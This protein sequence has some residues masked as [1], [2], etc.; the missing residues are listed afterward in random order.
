MAARTPFRIDLDGHSRQPC[1][2]AVG[3]QQQQQQL[4]APSPPAKLE[5]RAVAP[6]SPAAVWELGWEEE[7]ESDEVLE[8]HHHS[9]W[10]G[11]LRVA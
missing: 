5:Q 7:E 10:G 1:H 2:G 11:S 4:A 6:N 8:V 3:G 9:V